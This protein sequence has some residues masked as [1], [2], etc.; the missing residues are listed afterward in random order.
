[1][2]KVYNKEGKL[3]IILLQKLLVISANYAIEYV[4]VQ[5]V[6]ALCSMR[7]ADHIYN[8]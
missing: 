1:M 8:I 4:H 5:K 7:K 6:T 2:T 3:L